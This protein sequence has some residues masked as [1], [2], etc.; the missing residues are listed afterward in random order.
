MASDVICTIG[1]PLLTTIPM[2]MLY[3]V[4]DIAKRLGIIIGF[5][6]LFSIMLIQIFP[7]LSFL[8]LTSA[9]LAMFFSARRIE[10]FAATSAFAAVQV[11]YVIVNCNT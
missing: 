9:S 7:V 11:V 1:A 6:F 4:A 8:C 5:T 3:V 2:F 10:I